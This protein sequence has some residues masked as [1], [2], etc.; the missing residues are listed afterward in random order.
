MLLL[1][2]LKF[3]MN[4]STP[5]IMAALINTSPS[6]AICLSNWRIQ[7]PYQ[8]VALSLCSIQDSTARQEE[9]CQALQEIWIQTWRLE[10]FVRVCL[11]LKALFSDFS[12]DKTVI[13]QWMFLP[14]V[15]HF[16][17]ND[18]LR[19]KNPHLVTL[20][21]RSWESHCPLKEIIQWQCEG[22]TELAATY[23]DSLIIRKRLPPIYTF[24]LEASTLIPCACT[25]TTLPVL[26]VL[27]YCLSLLHFKKH[28]F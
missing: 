24:I 13:V 8:N 21:L 14:Q 11:S 23:K 20:L 12:L 15:L 2:S 10:E 26:Y 3:E 4:F 16:E 7:R 27:L 6:V 28:S 5:V 17:W 18:L 22:Q 9:M 19:E 25:A 1:Y